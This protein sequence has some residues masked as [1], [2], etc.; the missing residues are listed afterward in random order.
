MRILY[1]HRTQSA[2]GQ[3]VHIRELTDALRALGHDIVMAGPDRAQRQNALDGAKGKGVRQFLPA[4]VHEIAE[5]A[6]SWA[7]YG[8]MARLYRA[9]PPDIIYERYNLFFH[10]GAWLCRRK[11]AP[12]I[13]EVNAPLA[14][15]RTHEGNLFWR[16][17][18]RR[19]ET[20]IWRA[21]DIVLPV[22]DV[23][24]DRVHAAGV[25][26][27][28]IEV[29]PNAVGAPFLSAHDPSAIRNR[30]GLN[31]KIVLGFSG[32]IREWHGVDRVI[33]FL[34]AQQRR[35][36]H[37][38]I[39]G[40]G[41]AR[42]ALGKLAAECGVAEQIS[43]AGTVQREDMPAYISAFHIALQP[44]AVEYASP[45]KLFEYM[46]LGKPV[47]APDQ[48]NLREIVTNGSD[49]ILFDTSSADGFDKAL[50][51]LIDDATLRAR[52]GDTA[53]TTLERCN[54]TWNGN[55]ARVE[56]IAQKLIEQKR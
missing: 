17:A 37:L 11:G 15:E 2:D 36:L 5:Y 20:A 26:R 34:A 49:G 38:L 3:Q 39:V 23:L 52:L 25:P 21:A 10:A 27:D 44:A 51:D 46:A 12:L 7:A 42:P 50:L 13:L 9:A 31:G 30:L 19:S 32:F 18:A 22:T 33:K 8:R 48:P 4:P 47:L 55:A 53:R 45:L 16:R 24:A 6:Y 28:R 35:D 40:D 1:S 43:F 54:Y 14:E 41:P 56:L 29:I